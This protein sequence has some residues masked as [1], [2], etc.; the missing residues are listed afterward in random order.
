MVLNTMNRIDLM[1][2]SNVLLENHCHHRVEKQNRILDLMINA[3]SKSSTH[4]EL[5]HTHNI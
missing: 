5:F 3:V 1:W 4:F 2:C